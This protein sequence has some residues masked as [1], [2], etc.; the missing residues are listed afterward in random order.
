[1]FINPIRLVLTL[2]TFFRTFRCR[3]SS[4]LQ[5]LLLDPEEPGHY[6][7][8]IFWGIFK[9]ISRSLYVFFL[10]LRK[11]KLMGSPCSME[12]PYLI[13][14][15]QE[16]ELPQWLSSKESACNSGYAGLIPESERGHGKGN[17]NQLQYFCL[18]NP[19]DRGA[20]WATVHRVAKSLTQLKWLNMLT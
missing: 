2:C 11:H 19:T 9:M 5:R 17:G 15:R 12:K 18:E 20:W 4:A 14:T 10:Y 7:I 3:A 16:M 8:C 6:P 1:M 13:S